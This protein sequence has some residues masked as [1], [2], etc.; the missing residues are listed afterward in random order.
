MS[1]RV[2]EAPALHPDIAALGLLV[3][4]WAGEGTGEYPT[5]K[6]FAYGE[7]LR[8]DHIGKPFLR[9]AQRTW[10][11]DDG[12]PLHSES[13]YVRF[14]PPSAVELVVAHPIGVV[15][16]AEGD[17][18]GGKLVLHSTMIGR[19]STAKEVTAIT[20]QIT[21][22]GAAFSYELEMA[23]VGQPLVQHLK[24]TLHRVSREA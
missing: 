21:V 24:A 19:T 17:I 18:E 14:H 9:Y 2:P 13:G 5:T 15:E 10:S 20:R 1:D 12:R 4:T 11:T 16:V 23:A 8:F 7:E 3:G 6:P 22:E